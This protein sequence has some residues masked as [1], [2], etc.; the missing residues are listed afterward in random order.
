MTDT[1]A[2]KSRGQIAY[3]GWSQGE[4]VA[5][6]VA[7]PLNADGDGPADDPE[8]VQIEHQVWDA[9]TNETL[10][11]APN[12]ATARRIT[13]IINTTPAQPDTGAVEVL[14]QARAYAL[15]MTKKHGNPDGT[16]YEQGQNDM[17]FRWVSQID[18]LIDALSTANTQGAK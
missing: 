16:D 9:A 6:Y 17:G 11:V 3:E 14:R 5:I 18:S 13:S 2:G 8:T 1:M 15:D 7:M 10:C 12:E 4:A